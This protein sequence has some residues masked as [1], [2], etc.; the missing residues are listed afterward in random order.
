MRSEVPIPPDEISLT[1]PCRGLR[2]ANKEEVDARKWVQGRRHCQLCGKT[3]YPEDVNLYVY[4]MLIPKAFSGKWKAEGGDDSKRAWFC[5]YTCYRRAYHMVEELEKTER[6][7]A[8]VAKR[9]TMTHTCLVCG[10]TFS[11]SCNNARYCSPECTNSVR[12]LKRRERRE[13]NKAHPEG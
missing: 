3:F 6:G 4:K 2:V 1:F 8:K 11:S 10:K 13:R 9:K 5:G 12:N 7:Y